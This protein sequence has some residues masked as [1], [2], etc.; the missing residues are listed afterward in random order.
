[1]HNYI[2]YLALTGYNNHYNQVQ[3]KANTCTVGV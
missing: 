1:M 2:G 3:L